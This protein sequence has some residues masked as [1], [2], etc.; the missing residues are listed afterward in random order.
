MASVISSLL[1]VKFR[2]KVQF[3]GLQM[4]EGSQELTECR[5]TRNLRRSQ[6]EG[7]HGRV[8]PQNNISNLQALGKL[9]LN[10]TR[11][12]ESNSWYIRD[13]QDHPQA[14]W[15]TRRKHRIQ[16]TVPLT[17]M[18]YYSERTL[19]KIDKGIKYIRETSTASLQRSS[20]NGDTKGA[21]FIPPATSCH[22][23]CKCFLPEKLIRVSVSRIFIGGWS[24]SHP[25]LS[26]YQISRFSKWK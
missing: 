20:P 18:I 11:P 7:P 15:F 25:L 26:M 14:L 16:H 13:T 9:L 17:A 8:S 24:Q 22:N 12:V 5:V 21:C 6:T 19:S 3:F 23:I 4:S 1:L 10:Y 2:K